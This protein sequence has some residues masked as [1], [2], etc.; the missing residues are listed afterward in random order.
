[1]FCSYITGTSAYAWTN[2]HNGGSVSASRGGGVFGT[3]G[4]FPAPASAQLGVP[5]PSGLTGMA[6]WLRL[7]RKLFFSAG[8]RVWRR[9]WRV[10]RKTGKRRR[11]SQLSI[12]RHA[13][14]IMEAM[15]CSG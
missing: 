9:S 4:R 14:L 6:G 11:L 15:N 8:Y 1:M 5:L 10:E 12:V 2:L 13:S 3:D 7:H